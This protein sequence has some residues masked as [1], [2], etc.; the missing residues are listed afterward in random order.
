MP[1]RILVV[2]TST[3]P[4]A[5]IEPTVREHAGADAEVHIVAPASKISRLDRLTNAEDDARVDA[6]ERAETAIVALPGDQGEA[7]VGDVDPLQAIADALRMFPADEL[8]LLTASTADATWIESGLAAKAKE[9]FAMTFTHLVTGPRRVEP[10]EQRV[11]TV[12]YRLQDGKWVER[13]YHHHAKAIFE[14]GLVLTPDH[15][16][17]YEPITITKVDLHPDE[18]RLGTAQAELYEPPPHRDDGTQR[19]T[20]VESL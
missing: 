16:W 3:V 8:V 19:E 11:Y 15:G 18:T 12:S 1:R 14:A 9:R 6:A 5:D 2:T 17:L 10:F 4:Q 20:A 7:H 13:S